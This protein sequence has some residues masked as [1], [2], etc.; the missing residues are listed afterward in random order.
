MTSQIRMDKMSGGP[1]P[2]Q[3]A[4]L[5]KAPPFCFR[6]K[7]VTRSNAKSRTRDVLLN[8]EPYRA[9]RMGNSNFVSAERTWSDDHVDTNCSSLN[10]TGLSSLRNGRA[11]SLD[12]YLAP[13]ADLYLPHLCL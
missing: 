10:V 2:Q 11:S 9:D 6:Q 1:E 8:A 7:V 3:E 5:S 4:V 13:S 12:P